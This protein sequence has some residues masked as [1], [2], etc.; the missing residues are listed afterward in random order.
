M[1]LVAITGLTLLGCFIA[2]MLRALYLICQGHRAASAQRAQMP[3]D[4]KFKPNP[5]DIIH[6]ESGMFR[7]SDGEYVPFEKAA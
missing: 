4:Y 3:A 2:L 7:V 5:D 1:S 6:T